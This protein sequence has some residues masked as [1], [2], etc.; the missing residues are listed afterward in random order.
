[1]SRYPSPYSAA[2]SRIVRTSP[3]RSLIGPTTNARM[4]TP[5]PPNTMKNHP[6]FVSLMPKR[7]DRYSAKT[8]GVEL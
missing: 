4:S 3:K 6:M 5:T 1:M 7:C 8:G 2:P